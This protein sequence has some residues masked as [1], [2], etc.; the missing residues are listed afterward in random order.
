[1][2]LD[3]R[4]H[5]GQPPRLTR[6]AQPIQSQPVTLPWYCEA[7]WG[8]VEAR[9]P[10][11]RAVALLRSSIHHADGASVSL[12]D[13][14]RHETGVCGENTKRCKDRRRF[15]EIGARAKPNTVSAQC[16]RSK[17][18]GCG[19]MRSRLDL[20]GHLL[21]QTTGRI[22]CS[23]YSGGARQCCARGKY[24]R[25]ARTYEGFG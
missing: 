18:R 3:I 8:L 6:G 7:T 21:H 12:H 16:R 24:F 9:G 22:L 20:T 15:D 23:L 19:M 25:T 11:R 2:L 1:M 13:T 4:D 5:R 10:L 17:D 14:Y